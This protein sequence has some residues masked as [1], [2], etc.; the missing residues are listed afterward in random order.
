[1]SVKKFAPVILSAVLLVT[2]LAARAYSENG[3]VKPVSISTMDTATNDNA[4]VE[5]NERSAKEMRGVWVSYIELDMQNES[6]KS[7][8]AFREKFKNI[9]ITS[10]NA[11]F[12]TL[13][14]QVRPFCDALYKSAYFPYSHILSGEQGISPNYDALKVMCE[15]CSELD[16]DIHAWVNPYRISTDSTPQVL[17][18]NNPYVIDNEIGEE[19][20]NGIFLNPAN[21]MAR[22]L[23][24]NG[25]TEIVKNYDVD[26]IQFD[27][28]FYP[29]QDSEFDDTEY[30]DYVET[31]GEMNCMSIDN[32]RLANVNTLICDTY[33]AIH[34]ISD[35]VEF[36]ISPQGNID[37]NA[38]I[39]A[40]VKSW[41]IC[42][43]FVDYICPQLYY[44]LENPALTFENSLNS[45]ASLDINKNVKLYVGLAG[46]KAN[47][48]SDEG[49]WLY[50]DNVLSKEYKIAVNNEKVSGI[51]LYSY[52]ALIDENASTEIANLTKAM[53]NNLDA[54][55][56]TTVPIQ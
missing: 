53:S 40:D 26:G 17:S 50:S 32:W 41:C 22:N 24:I 49:T 15:I 8:S 27:D 4:K 28:Y 36:G 30:A 54:E 38:K 45:W 13:I 12:N 3:E 48:D 16:L 25:V 55:N 11:G 20:E 42:K 6:D 34:K 14:V 43:G 56:Q 2:A 46:Y 7:E 9:A 44:S 52:S 23:I 18:E 1:M 47:T 39:Y 29:T 10:K 37:N 33:R 21:K 19:T 35:D 5:Q 51:M 31:V